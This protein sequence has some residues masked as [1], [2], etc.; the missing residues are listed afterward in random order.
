MEKKGSRMPKTKKCFVKYL[1]PGD[2]IKL[3]EGSFP[4]VKIRNWVFE[5]FTKGKFLLYNRVKNYSLEVDEGDID[6]VEFCKKKGVK[7]RNRNEPKDSR[8]IDST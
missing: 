6:W 2:P 1:S 5:E 8:K 7:C 4:H 3:S